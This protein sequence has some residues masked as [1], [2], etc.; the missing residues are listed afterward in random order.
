MRIALFLSLQRLFWNHTLTTLGLNPLISHN[1]SWGA[2]K[3]RKKWYES[4]SENLYQPVVL[5]GPWVWPGAFCPCSDDSGTKLGLPVVKA[6]SSQ[7]IA[8]EWGKRV[9]WDFKSKDKPVPG[10]WRQ[11]H[12]RVLFFAFFLWSVCFG[13]KL[14][15]TFAIAPS[16]HTVVPEKVIFIITQCRELLTHFQHDSSLHSLGPR[17]KHSKLILMVLPFLLGVL[18]VKK[19]KFMPKKINLIYDVSK[20]LYKC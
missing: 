9:Q 1:C 17:Y 2:D 15:C 13:T 11:M 8:P 12:I 7:P 20:P 14:G 6:Q 18:K 16:F 10:H 4:M 19:L 3:K 5:G